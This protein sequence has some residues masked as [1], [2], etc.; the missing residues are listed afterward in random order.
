M[1][2]KLRLILG[3]AAVS[4]IAVGLILSQQQ[5]STRRPRAEPRGA[6]GS[7]SVPRGAAVITVGQGIPG[8]VIAPGFLGLSLEYWAVEAYAGHDPALLEQ[9]IRDLTPDQAP[10]LRIGGDSTDWTWFPVPGMPR[11]PGVTYSLGDRWFA[12]TRNL[13]QAL[14]ARLILGIDLEA[15][16]ADVAATE[17]RALVAGIGSQSIEGLELG[18]EPELYSTFAWYT[19]PDGAAVPGRPPGY[20]FAAF[21]QNFASVAAA[22][23]GLPV[24]GPAI[25]APA[26]MQKLG[27]LIAA[28]PRLSLLTLHRYPLV[29]CVPRRSPMFPT[30]ANL[31]A[32]AAARG[33]ADSVVPYV[34][35]AK[36]HGLQLRIDEMNSVSCGTGPGVAN[37]F[38]SA[39][40]ALNAAFQMARVGVDGVNFHTYP[41]AT[42]QLF[43][44][45]RLDGRWQA[46]VYPEYY[47]LLMFA[48]AAPPR[49]QLLR[50]SGASPAGVSVWATR[51]P[52][53]DVRV[54]LIDDSATHAHV[55]AVRIPP[56]AGAA[57]SR[58]GAAP[59]EWLRAPG[60]RARHGITLAGQ[61]FGARTTTG[62]LAGPPQTTLVAPVH[63]DYV[64]RL[65]A[66]SAALLEVPSL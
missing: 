2:R 56:R 17:A 28:E 45:R 27:A 34:A 20:D 64:V 21:T 7:E 40:W 53:G 16:S 14:R 61:S 36:Q 22:L 51:A 50:V 32:P 49:S 63:G 23:P 46:A 8:R 3:L 19:A 39:L 52:R 48:Q 60:L 26:W 54:L 30:I 6:V 62:A 43:G 33:L 15:N 42:Y 12:M 58:A 41:G 9:L 57:A 31:L 18:N 25:G 24:A 55:I 5:S 38:A 37:V 29:R 35:L 4:A 11:P 65:P 47:G 44:F 1:S 66:A 10:V 59:L 13:A